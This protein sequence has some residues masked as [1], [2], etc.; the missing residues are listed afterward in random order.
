MFGAVR[1]SCA[2]YLYWDFNADRA[3]AAER[4]SEI[5]AEEARGVAKRDMLE[6]VKQNQPPT[7][8]VLVDCSTTAPVEKALVVEKVLC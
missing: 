6:E 3:R 8:S 4:L 1:G 7:H 5:I 2:R